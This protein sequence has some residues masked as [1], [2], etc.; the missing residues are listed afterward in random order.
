MLA[1]KQ[2]SFIWEGVGCS[3]LARTMTEVYS[4]LTNTSINA[5]W[6]C[7]LALYGNGHLRLDLEES[8]SWA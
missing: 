7:M 6:K 4:Q 2:I 5:T 8:A 3:Y 1:S